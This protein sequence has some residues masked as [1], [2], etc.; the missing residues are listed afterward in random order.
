MTIALD[1]FTYHP[2]E[3][4]PVPRPVNRIEY[5][6]SR[7]NGLRV[8]DLG[9]YDETEVEKSQ[10]RSWRWLHAEI[11]AVRPKCWESTPRR[12]LR[13]SGGVTTRAALASCIGSCRGSRDRW[14]D[15]F[16]PDLVVAG[17]LIEHTQDTLGWL[18]ALGSVSPGPRFGD[19]TQCHF[20]HQPWRCR[21]SNART[22]TRTISQIYSFKTLATLSSRLQM[23]DVSI[24]PYYYQSHLFQGRCRGSWRRRSWRSTS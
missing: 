7:C 1:R 10:H 17:E 24:R 8:L 6:R 14:C 9:A 12:K 2:L 3:K 19:D 18:T 20:D 23:S 5:I 4:L 16:R 11:A 13:A 15:E 22:I 21:S